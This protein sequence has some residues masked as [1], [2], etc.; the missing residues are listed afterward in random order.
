M[1]EK[2]SNI[3]NYNFIVY[4][5]KKYVA[6]RKCPIPHQMQFLIDFFILKMK[7]REFREGDV[8]LANHPQAGGSHLPDLT[9]ITPVMFPPDYPLSLRFFLS[10][11]LYSLFLDSCS[12]LRLA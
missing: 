6:I 2:I 11:I 5:E 8:I 1:I 4:F 7:Q 12:V 10:F 9:V 3:F